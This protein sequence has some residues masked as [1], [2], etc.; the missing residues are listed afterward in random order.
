VK[1]KNRASISSAF[2]SRARSADLRVRALAFALR[3]LFQAFCG[4]GNQFYRVYLFLIVLPSSNAQ[5]H[6]RENKLHLKTYSLNF[7]GL[8]SILSFVIHEYY[9]G[10]SYRS[11]AV[12]LRLYE[13]YL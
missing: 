8:Y 13:V 12:R 9:S 6:C 1:K 10:R 11:Q 5:L 4:L 3:F 7:L 2:K